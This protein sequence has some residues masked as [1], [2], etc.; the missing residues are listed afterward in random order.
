MAFSI[1]DTDAKNVY[2][3]LFRHYAGQNLPDG[4]G[5]FFGFANFTKDKLI[6]CIESLKKHYSMGWNTTNAINRKAALEKIA[7]MIYTSFDGA[8]EQNGIYKF[9][10]WVYS[11]TQKDP[12]IVDYFKGDSYGLFEDVYKNVTNKVSS[13]ASSAAETV[14]Y[15]VKYPSLENSVNALS[16]AITPKTSTLIKWGLVIGAGW[17]VWR[18]IEKRIF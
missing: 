7:G 6:Y 5:V 3:A 10:C 2:N 14:S 18:F 1:T 12:D 11:F 17:F 16:N 15:G 4:S 9:L 8:V 13:A